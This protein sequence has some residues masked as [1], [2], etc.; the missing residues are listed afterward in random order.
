M[1]Q[2]AKRVS[3]SR[4]TV[5]AHDLTITK[6]AKTK[7]AVQSEWHVE[8]ERGLSIVVKP[9]GVATYYVRYQLGKGKRR[10]Q[11]RVAIGRAGQGGM[12][13]ADARAKAQTFMSKVETGIDPVAE[14]EAKANELTLQQLFERRLNQDKDT[15]ERTL[16]DYSM[17]LEKHILPTLGTSRQ[18]HQPEEFAELLEGIVTR[19]PQ[20]T[21][22]DRVHVPV[23][24]EA[25]AQR[26][27]WIVVNPVAGIGFTTNPNHARV[28]SD[29]ELAKLWKASIAQR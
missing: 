24:S 25:V 28:L 16:D 6:L 23:G 26:R 7:V 29:D 9:S 18:V 8:G 11:I 27:R 19:G 20:G 22:C 5:K 17:A 21:V 4:N 1:E 14:E 13:L 2:T 10:A 12:P 3:R 15:A